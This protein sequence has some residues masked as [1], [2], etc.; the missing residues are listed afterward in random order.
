MFLATMAA[1]GLQV[2]GESLGGDDEDAAAAAPS[3]GDGGSY[4]R[5]PR[6]ASNL[7]LVAD[8]GNDFD[9]DDAD[10]DDDADD[11]GFVGLPG[12]GALGADRPAPRPWRTLRLLRPA[13]H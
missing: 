13:R 6:E 11:A 12:S 1:C 4:A 9:A 7:G 2:G 8:A 5:P 3:E 10:A